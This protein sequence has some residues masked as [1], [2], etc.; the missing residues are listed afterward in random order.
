MGLKHTLDLNSSKLTLGFDATPGK[1]P[2][3]TGR[4]NLT[5]SGTIE[6]TVYLFKGSCPSESSSELVCQLM[7]N[8]RT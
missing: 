2:G 4:P 5:I 1:S 3:Y 6:G 7:L 8:F